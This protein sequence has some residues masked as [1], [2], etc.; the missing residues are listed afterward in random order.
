MATRGRPRVH[1]EGMSP[2]EI[3]RDW[4]KKMRNDDGRVPGEPKRKP[5]VIYLSDEARKVISD[6]RRAAKEAKLSPVL[7]SKLIE[8]LLRFHA[9]DPLREQRAGLS[10]TTL[11]THI[12]EV[13]RA[14]QEALDRLE[15]LQ[16]VGAHKTKANIRTIRRLMEAEASRPQASLDDLIRLFE[17]VS[18][19]HSAAALAD[20]RTGLHRLFREYSGE[21][22]QIAGLRNL[23]DR[24]LMRLIGRTDRMTSPS[25]NWK[26]PS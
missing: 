14:A 5:V 11:R 15:L 26:A 7:T 20:L 6:E 24:Y 1:P 17:T 23:L 2:A 3:K 18:R 10:A 4:D 12:A 22:E 13:R 16:T 8:D 21:R 9:G 19:Q 25:L